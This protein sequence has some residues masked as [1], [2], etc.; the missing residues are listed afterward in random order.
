MLSLDQK[1]FPESP[2]KKQNTKD[3]M[4]S[5]DGLSNNSV[6]TAKKQRAQL[7]KHLDIL[8]NRLALLMN[9]EIRA[10]K[11]VSETKRKTISMVKLKQMNYYDQVAVQ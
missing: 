7:E 8:K 11:L 10:N 9:E 6:W 2:S 4:I 5:I 3:L 1:N